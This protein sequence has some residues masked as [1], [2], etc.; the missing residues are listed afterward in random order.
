SAYFRVRRDSARGARATLFP[1]RTKGFYRVSAKTVV[2][3]AAVT[4]AV[5][6]NSNGEIKRMTT[7]ILLGAPLTVILGCLYW[8]MSFYHEQQELNR[9]LWKKHGVD[10]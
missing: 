8:V 4:C 3:P 10:I 2:Q 6:S 5:P 1:C 9:E 7:A